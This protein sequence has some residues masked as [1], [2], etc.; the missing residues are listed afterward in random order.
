MNYKEK[1]EY[2]KRVL[3]NIPIRSF[4]FPGQD[5]NKLMNDLQD[6]Y[7]DTIKEDEILRGHLFNHI[8]LEDFVDYLQERYN[9]GAYEVTTYEIEYFNDYGL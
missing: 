4:I 8:N 3:D 2:N 1:V 9:I 5:V 7:A 6:L